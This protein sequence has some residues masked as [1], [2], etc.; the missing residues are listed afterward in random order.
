M[1]PSELIQRESTD[2]A[3]QNS[4]S[5]YYNASRLR[6]DTWDSLR[7]AVRKLHDTDRRTGETLNL[8]KEIERL[9]GLLKPIEE[10]W[11]FPGKRGYN[12]LVR[13]FEREDYESLSRLTD[14]VLRLLVS[15]AYR[16]RDVAE[17]ITQECLE[18]GE[19]DVSLEESGHQ[20][21][22]SDTRPYF[23]VLIVDNISSREEERLRQKLVK[24]RRNEDEF[25]YNI[26]VVPTFEDALI[27][28]LFNYN[29]L[30]V[31]VRYSFPL[32]SHHQL[33]ILQ[34]TIE[35]ISR[36]DY[37]SMSD[38]DRSVALGELMN[39]LRPELDL[40]LVTDAPVEDIAGSASQ[41][42][43]RVFYR[44]EDY[45]EL[46]LSIL[47]GISERY[48]TPFFTALR[49]YSHK[50]TGVFHAMPL[51][52]GKS[53][54]KSHWIRDMEEF[55]GQNIFLAE[56]SAT[57][58]GLDSLLQPHGS[59][60][61]AQALAARAFG[62][63]RTYFVTNGT[64]TANK[65]VMQ[66]LVRP[67]DTVL[68]SR[69]CHK[70]HH[71]ALILA[72]AH[73]VYMDPYPLSTYSMYGAVPLR[74]I[75][76]QLLEQK[77]AGKLHRVRM[78]LLTN[79]TFDGITYNARAVMEELLAI[80]P[81]LIFLW[82]EAWFAYGHFT[83]ITRER[84]AMQGATDLRSMLKQPDY[85]ERY[86]CWRAEFDAKPD[87]EEEKLLSER[88]L[89]DPGKARVR[90]Y[91]TQSTHKTLTSLRQGSMIHIHDRDFEQHAMK[92]F[93]EAYMTHTSTSPNYQILASLDLGRRQVEL[94]G[95][96][97]VQKSIELAM[98]LRERI[99]SNPLTNKYFTV[100]GPKNVIPEEHRASGIELYY[101]PEA[102]WSRMETAW[103][104]DEF[105]LDPTRVTIEVGRTGM[106]GDEFKNYLMNEF[107][108]QINKTSRNTVLFMV[109]I[110]AT[111]GAIAYL[112]EVLA[113]IAQR[114][115]ERSE[116]QNPIDRNIHE[117]RVKSLTED[118]PPLP[119]F[120]RFHSSFLPDEGSPTPEGDMRKAFFLSY[121]E[122]TVEYLH[123][124]GEIEEAMA[125]GR[126]L[127][128][129][130]FVTPYPPGFPI[131]VPGQVVSEEIL[132]FMKALD[133]KE[134]HGYN[135][136]YGLGIFT[137]QALKDTAKSTKS[138]SNGNGQSG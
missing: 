15:D 9:F 62:A 93:N 39:R 84:M 86:A 108:I 69:D 94:E 11:A 92:A 80:K 121:D 106:D 53:I 133:V 112:I 82:D 29:I 104:R 66:A 100:L 50:P 40:F 65:I 28:I 81:D 37:E 51:S 126:D 75:K 118:L 103:E 125:Q 128:S 57:T 36:S 38:R 137:R 61:Q 34:R 14:R 111:R 16:N 109:H 87:S 64:S 55:Y 120:S 32:R 10:Y 138:R 46:H 68:V 123:I 31:V 117:S 107:D 27:A 122:S 136:K 101:D 77:R 130:S 63:K 70:S 73:P 8:R 71:Y 76:R 45:V 79:V 134:I 5:A 6:T 49:N 3:K 21:Q 98:T 102:G 22:F 132:S 105:A 35:S 67:G 88:L 116:D 90:V 56:T 24:L 78:V 89:P 20:R 99:R 25:I 54:A 113:T 114:I 30:S 19:F 23:E 52:R 85:P 1:I 44:Q 33:E 72:G 2:A 110:G 91:A 131:L 59:L 12:E 13:L 47:K 95:F 124:G 115:E 129:A 17:T 96:E 74:E 60:K 119:N 4:L 7:D 127:V 41:C 42:Y 26:V 135:P 97:L 58:G 18:N 43:R 83:P 48:D